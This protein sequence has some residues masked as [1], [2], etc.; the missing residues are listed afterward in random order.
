LALKDA[1]NRMDV[2][3]GVNIF[4]LDTRLKL[5]LDYVHRFEMV[6]THATNNDTLVLAVQAR[7]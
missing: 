6:A 2:A 1:G 3:G 4:L 5:Q 7:L